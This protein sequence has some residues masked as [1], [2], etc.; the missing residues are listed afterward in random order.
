[1]AFVKK[2]WKDRTVEF[3]GRR[4]LTRISGDPN[5]VMVVDVERAEGEISEEGDAFSKNNMNNLEQRIENGFA[6]LGGCS[7]MQEGEDFY[8]VGANEVKKKLGSGKITKLGAQ[9][10]NISYNGVAVGSV[11]WTVPQGTTIDQCLAYVEG[12]YFRINSNPEANN[13]FSSMVKYSLNGTILTATI[14]VMDYY[15]DYRLIPT[16]N[17]IIVS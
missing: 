9:V 4:K 7:F 11:S 8:I 1:M 3:A 10:V 16:L 17:A 15:A 2:T 12:Y 5:G 13:T 6:D 14:T